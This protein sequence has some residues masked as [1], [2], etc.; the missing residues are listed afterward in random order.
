MGGERTAMIIDLNADRLG[1]IIDKHRREAV[2]RASAITE[3][4][5]K[6]NIISSGRVD[7]GKMHETIHQQEQTPYQRAVTSNLHYTIYQEKG[8]GPVRPVKAKALRFKPKGSGTFVFAMRTKGFPGAHF[9]QK[10]FESIRLQ[11]FL[12]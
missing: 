1:N 10:A 2:E 7:T 8:I 9:F 11:D 12:A 6:A 5:V 4:R 3:K